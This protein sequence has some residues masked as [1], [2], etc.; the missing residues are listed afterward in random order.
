MADM[1]PYSDVGTW[2]VVTV[3][4]PN[5][6]DPYARDHSIASHATP[7]EPSAGRSATHVVHRRIP[8][9]VMWCHRLAKVPYRI[10][11]EGI[12]AGDI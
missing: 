1:R 5:A 11:I 7:D 6:S 12:V 2:A 10:A 4:S 8:R 3:H 9:V